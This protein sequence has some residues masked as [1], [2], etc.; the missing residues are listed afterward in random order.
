MASRKPVVLALSIGE[1]MHQY[2][3]QEVW[4]D[5]LAKLETKSNLKIAKTA[6]ESMALLDQYPDPRGIFLLDPGLSQRKKYKSI[7]K[8]VVE[9]MYATAARLSSVP[10]SV[11]QSRLQISTS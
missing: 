1:E 10:S 2:L 6:D 4:G 7:C 8:R 11:P 5:L 9:H 3:F